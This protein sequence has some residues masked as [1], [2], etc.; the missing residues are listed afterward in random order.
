MERLLEPQMLAWI[1]MGYI[2]LWYFCWRHGP[3]R[4]TRL[5][6]PFA[7]PANRS[8]VVKFAGFM[9]LIFIVVP[10]LLFSFLNISAHKDIHLYWPLFTLGVA[11][12]YAHIRFRKW[13]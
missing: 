11:A 4:G 9:S 6:G 3:N 8:A 2:T 13:T 5:G 1:P 10:V 12:A 7:A